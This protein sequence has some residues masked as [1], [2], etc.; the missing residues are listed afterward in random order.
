MLRA[1]VDG[2]PFQVV[3][4]LIQPFVKICLLN[5][6]PQDL[7]ISA[8]LLGLTLGAYLL[9]TMFMIMPVGGLSLSLQ[10][11]ILESALLL[12]YTHVAL[13]LSAHPERYL[14]TVSALAGT[15]VIIGILA[16]PLAYSLYNSALYGHSSAPALIAYVL[17]YAWLLVVYGHIYRH[18]LS[19]GLVIG[20]LVGLGYIILTS[21]V[22]DAVFPSPELP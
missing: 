4:A 2:R 3:Y 22:I 21:V 11:A 19:T 8:M 6:N 10:E 7:P 13:R 12:A 14:Q 5:A 17:V 15:S 16:L 20:V 9:I 18:A 1:C